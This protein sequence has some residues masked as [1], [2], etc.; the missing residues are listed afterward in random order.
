MSKLSL[1]LM[2]QLSI[3]AIDVRDTILRSSWLVSKVIVIQT[4]A[5]LIFS[6]IVHLTFIKIIL[7]HYF[8]CR[9]CFPQLTVVVLLVS[10]I[11]L[12]N[13]P[14]YTRKDKPFLHTLHLKFFL[15]GFSFR[16]EKIRNLL[17]RHN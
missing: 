5:L 3:T 10:G 16:V 13:E 7:L 15:H 9:E 11:G 2:L 17:L 4:S 8:P 12:D 14:T 1:V 6:K